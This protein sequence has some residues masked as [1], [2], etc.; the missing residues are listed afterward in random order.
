MAGCQRF[1]VCGCGLKQRSPPAAVSTPLYNIEYR[2][3]C[4]NTYIALFNTLKEKYSL[5][6]S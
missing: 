2:Y 3:Y 6:F 4:L 1:L 5:A